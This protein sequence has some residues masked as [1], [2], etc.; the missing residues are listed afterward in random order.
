MKA[1][2][3]YLL[4]FMRSTVL[5]VGLLLFTWY[6]WQNPEKWGVLPVAGFVASYFWG[7]ER[8]Y[9]SFDMLNQNIKALLKKAL[10]LL[11]PGI[12]GL[13]CWDWWGWSAWG[14]VLILLSL[15]LFVWKVP[16]YWEQ[17]FDTTK[18]VRKALVWLSV[19]TA[20]LLLGNFGYA[21]YQY[22]NALQS[23]ENEATRLAAIVSLTEIAGKN[24]SKYGCIVCLLSFYAR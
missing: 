13:C 14:I 5:F 17:I 22:Q 4:R 11:V 6:V 19:L 24:E 3:I 2:T 16:I 12:I 21:A 1:H 8:I 18:N 15:C 9:R 10:V 23:L 20:L 7:F